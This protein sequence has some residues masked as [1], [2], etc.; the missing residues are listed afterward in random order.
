[1]ISGYSHIITVGI[2]A[3]TLSSALASLVSAPKVFQVSSIDNCLIAKLGGYCNLQCRNP[4][5]FYLFQP[6]Y[7]QAVCK[8]NLFPYIGWFAKG[9]GQDKEPY[10]AYMLALIVAAAFVGIAE[11]NAIAP[12]ITNFFLISYALINYACFE[13]SLSKS[14]GKPI[15]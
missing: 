14:P 4:R 6:K 8:D 5:E 1:M 7:H 15:D 2:F 12:I 3:A 10:R 9:Y 13:A 11:L